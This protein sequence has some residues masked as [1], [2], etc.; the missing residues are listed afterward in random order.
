MLPTT[1]DRQGSALK[2]VSCFVLL[3]LSLFFNLPAA[4][5]DYTT[6]DAFDGPRSSKPARRNVS[7]D[8]IAKSNSKVRAFAVAGIP[9]CPSHQPCYPYICPP[10]RKLLFL[11]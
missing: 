8:R 3:T 7:I 9:G 10:A 1:D 4:A 5:G 11:L 2:R 6:T